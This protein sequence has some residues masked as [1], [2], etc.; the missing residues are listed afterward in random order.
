MA[1][2]TDTIPASRD[3]RAP[4]ITRLRT[5]LPNSSVPLSCRGLGGWRYEEKSARIGGE[6]ATQ[7]ARIARTVT[8]ANATVPTSASLLRANRRASL[9]RPVLGPAGDPAPGRVWT[10]RLTCD[11]PPA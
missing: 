10:A 7:G 9:R 3:A 6:G 11:L 2:L 5:S 8:T 1:R 4:K